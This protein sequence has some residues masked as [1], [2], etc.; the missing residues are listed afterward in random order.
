MARVPA[1][2]TAFAHRSKQV[3]TNIASFYHGGSDPGVERAWVAEFAR[4]IQPRDDGAYVNF[5][6]DD[7]PA[8]IHSAYPARTWER[9]VR[10]KSQYDPAN[11][12]RLNQ[13]I[14]PIFRRD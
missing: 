8:R 9:L 10:I 13:N 5:L 7:G 4:A 1:D 6:G 14:A 12:F 3:L 2:A 11:L